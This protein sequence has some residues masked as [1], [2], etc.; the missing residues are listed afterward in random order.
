MNLQE[1]RDLARSKAD[2][3]TTNF[4][5]DAELNTYINQGQRHIY[6]KIVQRFENYFITKGTSLNGGLITTVQTQQSYNMP[7]DLLKVVRVEHRRSGSTDDNE[8]KKLATLN[9]A[10][11]RLDDYFPLR[12]GYTPGFGYFVAGNQ[13][14]IKPVPTQ[15]Y[16]VRLWYV[17]NCVNLVLD[18]DIPVVP[19][20]Y[21]EL[22]S[23]YGAMQ[24]LRKSGESIWTENKQM[25][26][27]EL[28][29]LIET[30]EIRD[31]SPEQMVITDDIDFVRY[32]GI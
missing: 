15:A 26:E 29:N 1:I 27:L 8:W 30:I 14:N 9:I 3:Q 7:T 16:E 12:E 4:I 17:P 21:H 10:S 23:E 24:C 28:Q 32:Y 22:I 20:M 6:M 19:E 11:D 31:Q 25:F 13:I 5:G 18:A 2:E